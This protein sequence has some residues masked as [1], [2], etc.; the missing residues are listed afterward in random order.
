MAITLSSKLKIPSLSL[1]DLRMIVAI[2][3][4]GSLTEAARRLG[5]SINAVS[6]RLAGLEA[7][8]GLRLVQ[9]T[10]RSQRITEAGE[11]LYRRA[12]GVLVQVDQA[13]AELAEER[14]EPVG[15]V[16]VELSSAAI[17]E[18]LLLRVRDL[19]VAHP[20][21]QVQLL[22]TQR[23]PNLGPELDLALVVG[24]PPDRAGLVARRVA[25]ARWSL[26]A[27]PAYV[28][29]YGLPQAPEALIEH[30]ALRL[31]GAS[32]QET[33]TLDGPRGARIT[34]PVRGGF[35]ADD[36]RVLGDATY[37]GLGIGVRPAGELAQAVAAG[38]LVE[39]LPGWTFAALPV[40]LVFPGGRERLPG[41]RVVAEALEAALRELG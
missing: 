37:A 18:G 35:E 25:M 11:R 12:L 27:A 16:R 4:G 38:R 33:W 13:E 39:V 28:A 8:A 34:V 14:G 2:V 6:R 24:A 29:R 21:L 30:A 23:A 7:E 9:R 31:H 20:R 17:T 15:P 36:S 32:P 10:T 22:V 40:Y 3:E 5:L 1:D 26:C 19:L 41:V